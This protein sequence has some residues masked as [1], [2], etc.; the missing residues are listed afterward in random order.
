MRLCCTKRTPKKSLKPAERINECSDKSAQTYTQLSLACSY[1]QS[2]LQEQNIKQ[3]KQTKRPTKLER[4]INTV[5]SFKALPGATVALTCQAYKNK[6][7]K[8]NTN[9]ETE[10]GHKLGSLTCGK[11]THSFRLPVQTCQHSAWKWLKNLQP[12]C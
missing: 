7:C 11:L 10:M 9:C 1:K 2:F 12:C 3:N 6:H 5:F 8:R 4:G